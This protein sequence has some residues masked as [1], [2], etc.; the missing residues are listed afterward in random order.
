LDRETHP[1]SDNL[2]Q[3]DVI[4]GEPA[5]TQRAYMEHANNLPAA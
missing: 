4:A 2:Q 1:V 3:R 5:I